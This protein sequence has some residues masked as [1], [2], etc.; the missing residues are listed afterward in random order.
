[1]GSS[2]ALSLLLAIL[3]CVAAGSSAQTLDTGSAVVVQPGMAN[4]ATFA[5]DGIVVNAVTGEPIRRALVQG[6]N[7][8][9]LTGP[10]GKFHLDNLPPGQYNFF[11]RK[12]GYFNDQELSQ[13]T[14]QAS[15]IQ[16]G[17]NMLPLVLKLTPEAV[18]YGRI[19]GADGESLEN[20]PVRLFTSRV[21]SG[22]R[23]WQQ[24]G[25]Q[26]TNDDGQFR[27][28]ELRPGTYYLRAGQAF[29][30]V[31]RTGDSQ[32]P[33]EG[34]ASAFYPGTR[35]L[36]SAAAIKVD[37]GQQYRAEF[38]LQPVP[39]YQ[40]SGTVTGLT[41]GV[42]GVGIQL[43]TS[44]GDALPFGGN[45]E[46]ATGRFLMQ[47]V[48]AG[49]YILNATALDVTTRQ[50]YVA[51]MPINVS[52]DVAGVSL[53]LGPA[54]SIP[55]NVRIETT[56]TA[57]AEF[58]VN[59][60]QRPQV[61]LQLVSTEVGIFNSRFGTSIEGPPENRRLLI[62][63]VRPGTFHAEIYPL[64]PFYVSEAQSGRV[65]LLREELTI[66]YGGSAE[67]IE[68]VLRDDVASLQ[69]TVSVNG[70]RTSAILILVPALAPRRAKLE[71]AQQDGSFNI[72]GLAPGEYRILALDL[73]E[74]LEYAEPNGLADFT[75]AMQ[76]VRL[77][78][79]QQGNVALELVRRPK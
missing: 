8:A 10:D 75:A 58:I 3:P 34:Y 59:G 37:A 45:M 31:A 23:Q 69:G 30:A 4:G 60:N 48:P 53:V 20:L 7:G 36:E 27:I 67:P 21:V 42:N 64:G 17:P 54:P 46:R 56:R 70:Q 13:G 57:P 19:T 49:S 71:F 16:L 43:F 24:L 18:I 28:A 5:V 78:P 1:M 25:G 6:P 77:A 61:N 29:Q 11:A 35:D 63:N 12:P 32:K 73:V 79:N 55:V 44:D 62:R 50:E 65:D 72:G 39:M 2:K 47:S 26:T 76:T 15:P 74:D 40:V 51:R 66:P 68:I 22:R 41:V 52:G 33:A 38:S 9:L 14:Y